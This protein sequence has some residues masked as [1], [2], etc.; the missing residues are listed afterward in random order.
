MDMPEEPDSPEE[1]GSFAADDEQAGPEEGISGVIGDLR[2]LAGEA[3]TFAEAE[4]AFQASRAKVVTGSAGKIAAFAAAA[5]VL[6]VFALFALMM[7]VL[8][9]L[10]VLVGAWAATGI[11]VGTL[12]LVAVLFLIAARA[13]WRRM[14]T[15]AFPDRSKP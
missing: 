2:R 4:A 6:G 10:T 5:V 13:R 3:R 9:G 11:V 15:L 7:G 12:I 8:L 1:R 14:M